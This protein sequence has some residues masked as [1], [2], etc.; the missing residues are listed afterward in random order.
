MKPTD[1]VTKYCELSIVMPCL[2]EEDTIGSC[3]EKAKKWMVLEGVDGEIVVGDNGSVDNSKK[4]AESLGAIVISVEEK[5]YG[6]ALYAATQAATGKYIIF[7]DADDSYDFST[8]TPFLKRLRDGVDLVMGNRFAGSI[9]LGAMPW[10]N[11]YIGNPFLSWLGRRLFHTSVKDF[12][13]GLRGLTRKAFEEMDLKTTGME[14]ASEIVIKASI[15]GMKIDQVPINLYKDG[16]GKPPHLKPWRDGWRHLRFMLLFSPRW[17]F[18]YPGCVFFVAGVVITLW[19]IGGSKQLFGVTFDIHTLLYALV[20]SVLGFQAM[21][22]GLLSRKISRRLGLQLFKGNQ[23]RLDN[24]FRLENCL[25]LGVG[26]GLLG[27]VG[28]FYSIISWAIYG[29]NDL[30]PAVVMRTAIPSATML[31]LGVQSILLGFLNSFIDIDVRR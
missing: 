23:Y 2:N 8:L 1:N 25:L 3:I 12:H 21:G 10:K 16:R 27:V 6:S 7:G 22:F 17:L 15:Q 26:L 29:F 18:W 4:I 9:E 28:L 11:R 31:I 24:F 19:L 13:C 14:Y 20:F 30:I 5:G